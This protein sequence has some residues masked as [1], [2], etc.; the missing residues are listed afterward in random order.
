MPLVFNNGLETATLDDIVSAIDEFGNGLFTI[1]NSE[2][3]LMEL[4]LG[5][6]SFS[7]DDGVNVVLQGQYLG[8]VSVTGVPETF[9]FK[10]T[11]GDVIFTGQIPVDLDIGVDRLFIG[12]SLL[13]SSYTLANSVLASTA[14]FSFRVSD[15][16]TQL[17]P[18]VGG[19]NVLRGVPRDFHTQTVPLIGGTNTIR[20]VVI[21][22]SIE[23]PDQHTQLLP[24][25]GGTNTITP[26]VIRESIEDPDQHTQLPPLISGTNT[27][28]PV[29]IY[30]DIPE[31]DQHTQLPPLIGGT[32]TIG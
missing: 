21:R 26:V 25:I 9:S 23:D 11:N 31:P 12:D 2:D 20:S 29:V 19:N 24:L 1:D 5:N 3:T 18:L 22:E 32:N 14:P 7:K 15:S 13:L 16:H 27:I 30:R 17:V 8:F 10:N 4:S 28:T 6:P